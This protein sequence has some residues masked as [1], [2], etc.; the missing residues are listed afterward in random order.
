MQG[1]EVIVHTAPPYYPNWKIAHSYANIWNKTNIAG[2]NVLRAPV[3][4]PSFPSGPNRILHLLTFTLTS[5]VPVLKNAVLNRPDV[6]L[7]IAPS[8][9][10]V[11]LGWLA[12]KFCAGKLWIHVQDFEVEA[13]FAMN[14]L[15]EETFLAKLLKS[16]ERHLLARA[17]IA[18]TISPAMCRKLEN[19]GISP[20]KIYEFRN[21]ADIDEIEPLTVPSIYRDRWGISAEHIALYSGNIANKQGIEVLIDTAKIMSER[22]D[23]IFVICGNGSNRADLE[24]LAEGCGNVIFQDLQPK[25]ALSELLGLATVHLL[26]QIAGAADLVLPSKLANML[27]SGRPVVATAELGTGLADEIAGC[28]V[29]VPPGDPKALA[30]AITYLIE[31]ESTRVAYGIAA[32][33]RATQAWSK[34]KILSNLFYY[35]KQKI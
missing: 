15:K 19:K 29:V 12:T 24:K 16:F 2:V 23:V 21:W 4:V 18:T 11:P 5:L 1:C 9:L 13:A 32:R 34:T 17:G 10:S 6:I 3:Y 8:L 28:G 14:L 35:I 25:E 26:P 7:C 27:A 33:S 22:T 30:A 20:G 31:N